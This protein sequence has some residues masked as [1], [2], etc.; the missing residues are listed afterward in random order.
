LLIGRLAGRCCSGARDTSRTDTLAE[1]KQAANEY[2]GRAPFRVL[3]RVPEFGGGIK[4]QVITADFPR[5]F[6]IDPIA[7]VPGEVAALPVEI[8]TVSV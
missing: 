8:G 1:R 6:D 2:G 7:I 5:P 3:A 4:L